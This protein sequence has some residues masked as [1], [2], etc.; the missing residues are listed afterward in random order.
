MD[1][2]TYA[3]YVSILKQELVP[4]LG[5]TEPIAIAYCSSKAREVLGCLPQKVT[6]GCSG[7]IIKNVMG[8]TVPNSGGLKGIDVATVLGLVGGNPDKLLETLQDVTEEHILKTKELLKDPNYCSCKLV[9]GDD[10][11]IIVCEME[12]EGH[13]A[14]VEIKNKH[15]HITRIEKDGVLVFSQAVDSDDDL[16]KPDYS[17]LNVQDIIAFADNLVMED[18]EEILGKQIDFNSEISREGLENP[19]GVNVGK[20]LLQRNGDKPSVSIKARAAAAAGSDA[21]MS[22]CAKPVIINSGSGNQ[23]ITLTMPIVEYAKE[24]K[25]SREM[26]LKSLALANLVAIHQKQYIGDLSA[27]C[28]VVCAATGSASGVAYMLG[29]RYQEIS[30]TIINSICTVGGMVCDGAK[31]SCAAK[32]SIALEAALNGYSMQENGGVFQQG[33]GMVKQDVESTIRSIGQMAQVGMQSTDVEILRIM[34]E[35]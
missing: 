5:C 4:A 13:T 6:I 7:N 34:L 25:A 20:S 35:K 8:V 22:G 3:S 32:I 19:W 17:L 9:Q 16:E 12:G 1:K 21:R 18:V 11:L 30:N 24:L 33:E 27:Y 29:G 2:S 31:P 10:N 15:T 23:G 26:V 28:G 14:L